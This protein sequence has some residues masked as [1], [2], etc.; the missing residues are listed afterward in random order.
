MINADMRRAAV[1]HVAAMTWQRSPGGG[2]LRKR[3]HLVGPPEA[4]EVTSLVRYEAG[5]SFPAHDHPRGE[6]ILVLDG[7]F[8]DQTGDHAAGTHLLNAEGF[9]HA[10][11]S[12][13]GCLLFVK[14][15][16]YT[17]SRSAQL[18]HASGE[19][20]RHGNEMTEVR[21][22]SSPLTLGDAGGFEL[23]V[24]D[25]A[26]T[27]DGERLDRHDWCRRPPG[28]VSRVENAAERASVYLK[29]GHVASL[30]SAGA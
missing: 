6:E 17:G 11:W 10:P 22:V 21:D 7:V 1:A 8:S 4:G 13:G 25:G 5:A 26:V 24:I 29:H 16:Q 2:V 19:L 12:T 20:F 9:R 27:V 28:M 30:Q 23:F 18:P 14:L 15:R 3:F